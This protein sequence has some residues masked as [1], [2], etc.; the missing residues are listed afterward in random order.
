MLNL[1][2]ALALCVAIVVAISGT[3]AVPAHAEADQQISQPVLTLAATAHATVANDRMRAVLRAEADDRDATQAARV[4]NQR[5]ARALARAKG[6]AG[7]DVASAGYSTWQIGEKADLRWRV[8]Q[9]MAVESAD[10]AA[11]AALLTRLQQDEGLLLSGVE[12]SVSTKARTAAED[13]LVREAIADWQARAKLAAQAFGAA[14]WRPGRVSVQSI[15]AGRPQ[16]ML[17]AQGMVAASAPVSVE[18]GTSDLAV[19]VSGEAILQR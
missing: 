5:M 1:N 3:L 8:T 11:L 18:A 12:F 9:S 7:V 19:T 17:R 15:D 10:F 14:G 6:V 13:A 2:P 4:V 16:P